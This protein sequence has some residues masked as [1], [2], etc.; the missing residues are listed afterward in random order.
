MKTLKGLAAGLFAVLITILFTACPNPQGQISITIDPAGNLTVQPGQTVTWNV[1]LTPDS[2]QSSALG[3]FFV[4]VDQDTVFN[5]DLQGVTETRSFQVNYTVPQDAQ[6]G[7][8]INVTFVAIDAKSGLS[9]SVAVTLTVNAETYH[10]F[11]DITLN[12]NSTTLDNQMMLVLNSDGYSLAGGN[13]TDGIVAYMYNGSQNILNT[14]ASPNA[15]EIADAYDANG[16][17]YTTSDKHETYFKR[18]T[19]QVNWADIDQAAIDNL[20]IGASESDLISGSAN[21][22]YGVSTLA[23][24]DIIAFDNPATNVKGYILVKSMSNAKGAKISTTLTIDIKY[25]AGPVQTAK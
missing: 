20:S 21:L 14:L 7:Q 24:N 13:S 8:N 16:V 5:T 6:N 3:K 2:T 22:G 19:G 23:A 18:V 15:Q 17:T 4:I 9:S 25:V 1:T 10:E 12:W 11:Q